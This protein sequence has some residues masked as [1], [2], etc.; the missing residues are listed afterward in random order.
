MYAWCAQRSTAQWSAATRSAAQTRAHALHT[1]HS[2]FPRERTRR[3]LSARTTC[4]VA[5][6]G[7]LPLLCLTAPGGFFVLVSRH[8]QHIWLRVCSSTAR[9]STWYDD[10]V[11]FTTDSLLDLLGRSPERQVQIVVVVEVA[12]RVL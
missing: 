11:F 3:L 12:V 10:E 2:H 1:Q 9:R 6:S 7:L 8:L 4:A 5:Y